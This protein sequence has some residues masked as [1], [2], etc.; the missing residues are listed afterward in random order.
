MFPAAALGMTFVAVMLLGPTSHSPSSGMSC[1]GNAC[2]VI[3]QNVDG[4]LWKNNGKKNVTIGYK[5][6]VGLPSG[7]GDT[8]T[9][10]LAPGGKG[11]TPSGVCNNT[12]TANY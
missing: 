3:Q 2:N 1:Q 9:M 10:Q 4:A 6:V 5:P 7:C 12:F 8:T 11:T